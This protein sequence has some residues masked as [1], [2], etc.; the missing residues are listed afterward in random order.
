MKFIGGGGT[1][2]YRGD[3]NG[4]VPRYVRVWVMVW[5]RVRVTFAVLTSAVVTFA[6]LTSA[7]LTFAVVT[8][9]VVTFAVESAVVTFAV[10]T[11]TVVYV[12][13][14]VYFVY[15]ILLLVTIHSVVQNRVSGDKNTVLADLNKFRFNNSF[16]G[17]KRQ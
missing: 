8:F 3:K 6:V 16:C 10:V 13:R 9:A 12:C 14:F 7:V 5:V 2:I 1:E 15:T 17:S 4:P 11:S